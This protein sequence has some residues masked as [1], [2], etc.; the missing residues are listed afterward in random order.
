M[1]IFR[2]SFALVRVILV[3]RLLVDSLTIHEITPSYAKTELN[4]TE[5]N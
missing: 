4:Y 5:Q 2:L 3:D 1:I